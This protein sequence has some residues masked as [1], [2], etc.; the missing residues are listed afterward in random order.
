M[1]EKSSLSA[2]LHLLVRFLLTILLLYILSTYF[3]Q[4][5]LLTG[6]LPAYITVAAL[7]T[8]MNVLVRPVIHV[9]AM[10][11]HLI[12]GLFITIA[13]NWLFLWLTIQIAERFDP[14]TVR[15]AIEGGIAGWLLVAII[16]GVANWLMKHLV[17]F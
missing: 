17:R 10:P 9:L 1:A 13:A 12:F 4:Y 11:F 2:P 14:H 16:L 7:V 15:L 5:F 3:D 6:G 8:L